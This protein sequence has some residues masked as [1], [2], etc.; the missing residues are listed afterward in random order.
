MFALEKHTPGLIA[1]LKNVRIFRLGK[2]FHWEHMKLLH[3]V[4]SKTMATKGNNVK[5]MKVAG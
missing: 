1:L 3:G 5:T 2:H 4:P